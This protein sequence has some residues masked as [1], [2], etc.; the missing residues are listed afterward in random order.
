MES[1]MATLGANSTTYADGGVTPTKTVEQAIFEQQVK[2]GGGGGATVNQTSSV[3]KLTSDAISK[4]ADDGLPSVEAATDKLPAKPGDDIA[5]YAEGGPGSPAA[6]DAHASQMFGSFAWQEMQDQ[7]TLIHAKRGADSDGEAHEGPKGRPKPKPLPDFDE[8]Q[9]QKEAEKPKEPGLLDKAWDWLWNSKK[10]SKY[11]DGSE[12]ESSGIVTETFDTMK[13][14]FAEGLN[15]DDVGLGGFEAMAASKLSEAFSAIGIV[16]PETPVQS[17]GSDKS[18]ASAEQIN[19]GGKEGP[20]ESS[21]QASTDLLADLMAQL[22]NFGLEAEG[23]KDL[24][25]L[26]E[27]HPGLGMG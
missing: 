26:F 15:A 12:G 3:Q 10:T 14:T 20:S 6:D 1:T 25:T 2:G 9:K 27:T 17:I 13:A 23:L 19:S 24:E 16:V 21:K 5:L 22:N 11:T 18:I 8:Q 7:F 4:P